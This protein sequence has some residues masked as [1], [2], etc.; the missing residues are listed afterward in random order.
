ME[1]NGKGGGK[2]GE[3]GGKRGERGGK[4]GERGGNR[5]G[6]KFDIIL[7]LRVDELQ[8]PPPLEQYEWPFHTLPSQLP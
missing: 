1:V 8:V 6:R 4:R 2:R 3:K 5:R 7:G